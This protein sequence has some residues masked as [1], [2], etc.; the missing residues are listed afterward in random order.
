MVTD[1]RS[2]TKKYPELVKMIFQ[3]CTI[4]VTAC[5]LPLIAW[6][7]ST[8]ITLKVDLNTE[9][10]VRETEQKNI[11][12]NVEDYKSDLLKLISSFEIENSQRHSLITTTLERQVET[13]KSDFDKRLSDYKVE[14]DRRFQEIQRQ[15]EQLNT[16]LD[17]ALDMLLVKKVNP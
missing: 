8:M 6:S 1:N 2:E 5:C 10:A 11:S 9:R 4:L 16:K 3:I 17:K 13:L 12:K 7:L 14:N 15:L